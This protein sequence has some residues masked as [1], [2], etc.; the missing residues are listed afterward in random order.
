MRRIRGWW[1][2]SRT[3]YRRS[4][5]GNCSPTPTQEACKSDSNTSLKLVEADRVWFSQQIWSPEQHAGPLHL[6]H[7]QM[8]CG[9]LVSLRDRDTSASYASKC[10]PACFSSTFAWSESVFLKAKF[11]ILRE[12]LTTIC[13]DK[14]CQM[15]PF[16]SFS[17]TQYFNS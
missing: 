8:F 15:S 7:I 14:Q 16:S 3:Q 2:Q 10:V 6:P 17:H 5:G 9:S 4:L 12:F 1:G 13:R 11:C